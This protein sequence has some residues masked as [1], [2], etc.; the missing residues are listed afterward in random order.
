MTKTA[1]KKILDTHCPGW[2]KA[3]PPLLHHVKNNTRARHRTACIEAAL[4]VGENRST[5]TPAPEP[6][7]EG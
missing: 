3:D 4:I 6:E 2:K 5:R 1:A 7:P